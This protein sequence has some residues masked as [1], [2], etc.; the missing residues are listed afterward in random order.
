MLMWHVCSIHLRRKVK[1]LFDGDCSMCL[2][3]VSMLKRQDDGQVRHTAL[4]TRMQHNR[5]AGAGWGQSLRM[6]CPQCGPAA[7]QR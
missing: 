2:S 3:L 7:A 5:H 4:N 6:A 1:Y